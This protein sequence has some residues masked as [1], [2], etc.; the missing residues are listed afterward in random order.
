MIKSNLQVGARVAYSRA[1]LKS[2]ACYTGSLPM[3]R[4]IIVAIDSL[5]DTR[6]ATVSWNNDAPARVNVANLC[7][8]GSVAFVD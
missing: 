6:L 1:F 5:G 8:V 2:I 7:K 4:G 3:A